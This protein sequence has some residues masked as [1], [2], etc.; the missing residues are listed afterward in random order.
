MKLVRGLLLGIALGLAALP[1]HAAPSV[2]EVPPDSLGLTP[3]GEEIRIS[4][5]R[6]KV[7]VVAFW[8]SWCGYCRKQFPVLE[9]IQN[10]AGRQRL[11]VVLVNFKEPPRTYREIVR[12]LKRTPL[13]LTHD[14]DGTISYDYKVES[15]PRLF[16]IDKAGRVGWT[17]Y[18]Y[19]EEDLPEIG[20]AVDRLL[21]EPWEA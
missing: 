5:R 18:G 13:T 10:A 9:A 1:T 11:E 4:D 3:K 21:A 6:G 14:R 17:H 2:G 15:L 20:A 7:V 8:A 19:S 16:I 12:K